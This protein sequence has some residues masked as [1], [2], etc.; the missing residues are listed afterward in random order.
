MLSQVNISIQI[1]SGDLLENIPVYPLSG[2]MG[3]QGKIAKKQ[4][5][6]IYVYPHISNLTFIFERKL[7]L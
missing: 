4:S 6:K 5:G 1:C 3:N 7:I 2:I